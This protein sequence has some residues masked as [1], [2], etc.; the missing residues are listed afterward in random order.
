LI[1]HHLL[2][3]FFTMPTFTINPFA[4]RQVANSRFSHFAGTEQELLNRVAAAFAE[5]AHPD[6]V[7][8]LPV[9]ADGFFT[10]HALAEAG[11]KIEAKFESRRQGEA[12][13][14]HMGRV[15]EDYEAAK[16]PAVAVNIVLYPST[17]LAPKDNSLPAEAGNFEVVSI[18]ARPTVE[19]EPI[20]PEALIANH[21][22]EDG[23][24]DHGL[25]D[26]E[27]VARLKAS[28]AY[29]SRYIALA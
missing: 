15:V 14:F 22:G 26:A 25:S 28:R 6:G 1:E 10:G 23:G 8:V 18:N 29:H 4:R 21:L 12:P 19:E 17:M 20:A 3:E 2:L 5:R 7:V 27:F 24:T 9:D 11:M 16:V 13:R